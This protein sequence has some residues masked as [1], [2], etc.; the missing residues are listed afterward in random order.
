MNRWKRYLCMS[1]IAWHS[2]L[3]WIRLEFFMWIFAWINLHQ[4]PFVELCIVMYIYV[5][6]Y[7][8]Y[9]YSASFV[10]AMCFDQALLAR[11]CYQGRRRLCWLG[12]AV[13]VA[14][15]HEV[16]GC[17]ATLSELL[18]SPGCFVYI[19][20][21]TTQFFN[22]IFINHCKDPYK[23]TR[24]WVV[25]NNLIFLEIWCDLWRNLICLYFIWFTFG[26]LW[27]HWC[28]QKWY[29]NV[30]SDGY[31]LLFWE[32]REATPWPLPCSSLG[33]WKIGFRWIRF[34]QKILEGV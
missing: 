9:T 2:R 24:I 7:I 10:S 28:F 6:I 17:R 30:G 5:Y 3:H 18:K 21:Y 11:H 20:D 15:F 27:Q 25:Y 23:P 29:P 12:L 14:E 34:H 8:E 1:V 19:G 26:P 33:C 4:Y 32:D 13:A 31:R 16:D 22:V